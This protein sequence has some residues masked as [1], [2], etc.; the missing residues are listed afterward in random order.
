MIDVHKI[1][2]YFI[3][4]II[5]YDLS[6]STLI[7]WFGITI[8]FNLG[9]P[10]SYTGIIYLLLRCLYNPADKRLS[11]IGPNIH[12]P[13]FSASCNSYWETISPFCVRIIAQD[14]W[15]G[16]SV[17]M[18]PPAWISYSYVAIGP[19]Y[20]FI[21]FNL[22]LRKLQASLKAFSSPLNTISKI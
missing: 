3:I 22:F 13:A 20:I 17:M 6:L 15:I 9:F 21:S 2:P 7:F 14:S 12:R 11:I 1:P 19:D 5:K 10:D 18:T 4:P 8:F 16:L